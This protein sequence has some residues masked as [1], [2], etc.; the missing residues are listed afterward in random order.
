MNYIYRVSLNAK[1]IF[2]GKITDLKNH[3]KVHINYD[4]LFGR[5]GGEKSPKT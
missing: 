3:K 5:N 2:E 4:T 1:E